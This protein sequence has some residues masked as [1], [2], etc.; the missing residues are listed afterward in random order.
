MPTLCVPIGD[1]YVVLKIVKRQKNIPVLST[2]NLIIWFVLAQSILQIRS[3]SWFTCAQFFGLLAGGLWWFGNG[4]RL[5]G[6]SWVMCPTS[7]GKHPW[8]GLTCTIQAP[9]MFSFPAMPAVSPCF[10][11]GY[12]PTYYAIGSLHWAS[13]VQPRGLA[14]QQAHHFCFILLSC[15]IAW[16]PQLTFEVTLSHISLHLITVRTAKFDVWKPCAE[17]AVSFFSF[18]SHGCQRHGWTLNISKHL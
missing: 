2:H 4:F 7:D 14:H 5:H 3:N 13:P 11:H 16:D 18:G 1:L 12:I 8:Y 17:S 15:E 10:I 9:F 6:S